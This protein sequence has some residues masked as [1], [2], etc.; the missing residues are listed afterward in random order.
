[1]ARLRSRGLRA[2]EA[3][4]DRSGDSAQANFRGPLSMYLRAGFEPHRETKR[5]IIVRK[6]L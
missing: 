1:V 6:A 2:V 5:N 4:P 3:Y